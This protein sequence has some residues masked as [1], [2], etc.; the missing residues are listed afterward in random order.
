[1]ERLILTNDH[2]TLSTVKK[3]GYTDYDEGESGNL[4]WVVHRKRRFPV[5]NYKSFPNGDFV[6]SAG[7]LIYKTKIGEEALVQ[8]Y[9]DFNGGDVHRIRGS[10]LEFICQGS[11]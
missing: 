6:A 4:R 3:A 1:M 7:T 2:S 8:L 5:Q 9:A 10:A 11:F